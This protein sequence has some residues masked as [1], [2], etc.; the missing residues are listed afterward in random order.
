MTS[1]SSQLLDNIYEHARAAY[2]DECCGYVTVDAVIR[3]TNA[4]ASGDNPVAPERGADAGFVIGGAELLGFARSFDTARPALMVYHSHP[5]GRAY[6]SQVDQAIAA[7][8]A[9]PVDHLVVGVTAD[10]VVECAQ[11]A[12]SGGTYVEVARWA[13]LDAA[14]ALAIAHDPSWRA[15]YETALVAIRSHAAATGQLDLADLHGAAARLEAAASDDDRAAFATWSERDA[16][17]NAIQPAPSLLVASWIRSELS[18]LRYTAARHDHPGP[19][20]CAVLAGLGI[21]WRKPDSRALRWL[22]GDALHWNDYT[23]EACGTEWSESKDC[24]DVG[25]HSQ[26]HRKC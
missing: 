2:P 24:D 1:I 14:V 7:G 4:Q 26:W 22:A 10:G 9:Y 18:D 5:N 16:L 6:F 20:D 12:W 3:C 13:T 8:P 21:E 15:A 19:C 23:C 11:F 25:V 17:R